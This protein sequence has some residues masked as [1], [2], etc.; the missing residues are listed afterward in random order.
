MNCAESYTDGS[1][2]A[3]QK[4]A[5][6]SGAF[7]SRNVIEPGALNG[8]PTRN[9][10][11]E[12]AWTATVRSPPVRQ[13]CSFNPDSELPLYAATR[14]GPKLACAEAETQPSAA[15]V[16][17]YHTVPAGRPKTHDGSGSFG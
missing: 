17:V 4:D 3:I 5:V 8:L 13:P 16:Y 6:G 11:V 14:A 10:Y 2:G 1:F 7:S 9:E 12:P 15:G